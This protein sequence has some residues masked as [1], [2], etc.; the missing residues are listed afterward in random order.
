MSLQGRQ[1]VVRGLVQGVGF[2]AATREQAL[3]LNLRGS[4]LN[5]PDGSVQVQAFGSP[6]ALAELAQWL[7]RGPRFAR[8]S[9]VQ[10]QLLGPSDP[11]ALESGFRIGNL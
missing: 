4:A 8:V 6:V 11:Q 10:E 7:Q 3:R 9:S 5:G 2:R 1:F